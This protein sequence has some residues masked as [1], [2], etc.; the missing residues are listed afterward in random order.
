MRL[1]PW[2]PASARQ[3]PTPVLGAA[4][5]LKR[6]SVCCLCQHLL[7]T[8]GVQGW[9]LQAVLLCCLLCLLCW[10]QVLSPLHQ[11]QGWGLQVYSK[12]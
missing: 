1:A 11:L 7:D 10:T 8:E 2:H 9:G 4:G 12:V 5:E 6:L 3:T